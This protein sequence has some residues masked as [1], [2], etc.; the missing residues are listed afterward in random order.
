MMERVVKIIGVVGVLCFFI[1]SFF[2]EVGC[3]AERK[4]SKKEPERQIVHPDKLDRDKNGI[5]DSLERQLKEATTKE[6]KAK[7]VLIEVVLYKPHNVDQLQAF[8]DLGGEIDHV[9]KHVSYGFSGTIPMGNIPAL[10]NA[11]GEDLCIIEKAKPTELYPE[12]GVTEQK[13]GIPRKE[14][15]ED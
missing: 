15:D 10:A 6:K 8:R 12:L 3:F 9:F 1:V 5:E 7:K 14:K 11:L 13:L 2:A 4:E